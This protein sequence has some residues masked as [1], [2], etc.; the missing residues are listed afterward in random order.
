MAKSGQRYEKNAY[1]L[2]VARV[3]SRLQIMEL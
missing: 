1:Q 2:F 3:K